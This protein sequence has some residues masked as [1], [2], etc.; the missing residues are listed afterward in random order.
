MLLR[1][2]A[3]LWRELAGEAILLD[4]QE[5]CSYNLNAV[6]TLIWKMLDG[7]H[8]ISDIAAAICEKY[9]VEQKQAIEDIELLLNDLRNNKLLSDQVSSSQIIV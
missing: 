6:G 3:V 1:N 8:S 4:P 2:K 5:G 9:E 7:E